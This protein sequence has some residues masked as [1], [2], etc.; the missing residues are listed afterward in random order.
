L[1]GTAIVGAVCLA[2]CPAGCGFTRLAALTRMGGNVV[3]EECGWDFALAA[4]PDAVWPVP[5]VCAKTFW[6][7]RGKENTTATTARDATLKSPKYRPAKL[8]CEY[9]EVN[10]TAYSY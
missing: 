8:Q 7:T 2:R 9:D 10:Q 4:S 3:T 1:A 6:Q 5:A